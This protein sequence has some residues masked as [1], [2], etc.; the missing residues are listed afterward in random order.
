MGEIY[1]DDLRE[2]RTTV[3]LSRRKNSAEG[4][5]TNNGYITAKFSTECPNSL[6]SYR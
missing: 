6:R 4:D 3:E 5:M 2:I 1:S